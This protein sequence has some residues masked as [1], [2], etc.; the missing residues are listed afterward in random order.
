MSI[1]DYVSVPTLSLA[2]LAAVILLSLLPKVNI[3]LVALAMAWAV[4]AG[5]AQLP[6]SAIANAFPFS[7]FLVLFGVTLLFSQ[8]NENGTMNEA[9]RAMLSLSGEN[10]YALPIYF[11]LIT[12]ALSASGAGNINA[13]ALIAPIALSISGRVRI[14]ALLTTIMVVSGANAGALSPV[15]PTGIV[16]NR[17]IEKTGAVM[18][19]WLEVFLPSLAAQSFVA[20][21]SYAALVFLKP[22]ENPLA[23]AETVFQPQP[24]WTLKKRLTL[25]GLCVWL[26]GVSVGLDA[27]FLAIGLSSILAAANLAA[28]D[29]AVAGVPWNVILLV[30]GVSTLISVIEK[31]GGMKLFTSLLAVVSTPQHITWVIAFVAGLI[32][33]FASSVGVALPALIPLAPDLTAQLGSDNLSGVIA[34][35][36]VGAHLVDISPLSTLGALCIANAAP[37]ED[38]QKL[39]KHLLWYGLS[40]TLFGALVCYLFFELLR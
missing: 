39:F 19:P 21:A 30:C 37:N 27:G 35:I 25:L 23:V 2:S 28:H 32:S 3:G 12:L 5:A 8:A 16:A 14:S 15:A 38:K 22:K 1:S 9:V 4:G 29:R 11:F 6:L 34:S 17:L 10:R 13:T 20:V 40:M 26:V 33:S 36:N 18:S 7:M 24:Q 31:T